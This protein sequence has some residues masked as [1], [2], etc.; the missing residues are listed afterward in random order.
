MPMHLVLH[1]VVGCCILHLAS[2]LQ[3]KPNAETGDQQLK[4][5]LVFTQQ[6]QTGEQART[7]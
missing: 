1:L 3:P 7:F 2:D 6:L 4:G 5:D